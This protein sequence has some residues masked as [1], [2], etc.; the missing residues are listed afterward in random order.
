MRVKGNTNEDP[1]VRGATE[2]S[3][4]SKK[5]AKAV[6]T[7]ICSPGHK[8]VTRISPT[9]A[10]L[11]WEEP[12]AECALCPNAIAYEVAGDG[13]ASVRVVRPPC[14]ITGLQP[15]SEY[16]L[17]IWAIAASGT[18]SLPSP[19]RILRYRGARSAP[20]N[21]R[22]TANSNHYVS[23]AWD[24][25]DLSNPTGY[26]VA[27]LGNLRNVGETFYVLHN[28]MPGLPLLFGVQAKYAG[29]ENSVWVWITVIP[30]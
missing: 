28:L 16:L 6:F 19:V 23:I 12:Y 25:P 14:T 8:R 5:D 1:D 3:N 18:Q 30:L 9:T 17:S 29:G 20:E 7:T 27:V 11:T 22:V 10:T 21:L 15:D 24:T 2:L 4:D 13:I 26:R